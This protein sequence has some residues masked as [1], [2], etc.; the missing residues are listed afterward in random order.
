LAVLEYFFPIQVLSR[1][2]KARGHPGINWDFWENKNIQC[3]FM[4]QND[5]VCFEQFKYV[6]N[7]PNLKHWARF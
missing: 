2:F 7:S 6:L 1:I 5:T 3:I 4:Y